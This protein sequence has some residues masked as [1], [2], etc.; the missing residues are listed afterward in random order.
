MKGNSY[1]VCSPA[2]D[3]ADMLADVLLQ[4]NHITEP[5]FAKPGNIYKEKDTYSNHASSEAHKNKELVN[6]A[7]LAHENN[8]K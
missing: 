3:E 7:Y 1:I 2:L 8:N 4:N 6:S 5:W